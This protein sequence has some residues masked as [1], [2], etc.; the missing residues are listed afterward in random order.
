MASEIER[1]SPTWRYVAQWAKERTEKRQRELEAR[2]L[3]PDE[4]EFLRGNIAE[5]RALLALADDDADRPRFPSD[6]VGYDA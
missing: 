6:N 5:L 4:T 2:G 3:P 1:H